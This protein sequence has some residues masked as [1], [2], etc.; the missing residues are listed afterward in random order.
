MPN[1]RG[2]SPV[3]R[4]DGGPFI[5][6]TDGRQGGKLSRRCWIAAASAQIVRVQWTWVGRSP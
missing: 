5:R 6:S 4:D 3:S 2:A 1:L